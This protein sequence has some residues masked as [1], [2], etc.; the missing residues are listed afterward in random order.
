M[1][2]LASWFASVFYRLA[3]VRLWIPA[4][5]WGL[6]ILSTVEALFLLGNSQQCKCFPPHTFSLKDFEKTERG[7]WGCRVSEARAEVKGLWAGDQGG[8]RGG[9]GEGVGARG[10]RGWDAWR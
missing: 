8:G 3:S 2:L 7:W 1:V 9:S 10:S 6:H 5:F 4:S